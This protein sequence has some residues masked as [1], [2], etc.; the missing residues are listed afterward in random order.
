MMKRTNLNR[1]IEIEKQLSEL[2]DQSQILQSWNCESSTI[3]FY[4]NESG[5]QKYI[6]LSPDETHSIISLKTIHIKNDI[7]LLEQELASL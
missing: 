1:A 2:E 4:A 6:K 5:F 3:M 7:L